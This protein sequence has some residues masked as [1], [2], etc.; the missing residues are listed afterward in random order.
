MT[1]N[2]DFDCGDENWEITRNESG[3]Y[4]ITEAPWHNWDMS[5]E[6][7]DRELDKYEGI[8]GELSHQCPVF[9]QAHTPTFDKRKYITKWSMMVGMVSKLVNDE[10][11]LTPKQSKWMDTNYVG[12]TVKLVKDVEGGHGRKILDYCNAM[13]DY[14]TDGGEV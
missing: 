12:G 7:L 1:N 3:G 2:R 6:N 4:R 9:K 8:I 5:L 13:Y 10:E 14:V 11:P